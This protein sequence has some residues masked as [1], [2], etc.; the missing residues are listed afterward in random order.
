MASIGE[1][2][3]STRE[4]KGK[5]LEDVSRAT[6]IKIEVLQK[7]EADDYRGIGAPTYVKGFIKLY[8]DYLGLDGKSLGEAYLESQGG[9]RRQGLRLETQ[10][11]LMAER[12]KELQ[13]PLGAVVALVGGL[14]LLLL[15]WWGVR[16]WELHR[17]S[18]PKPRRL[19]HVNVEPFYQPK[20][21]IVAETLEPTGP[22]R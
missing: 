18:P 22:G 17:V 8:G 4:S 12:Q 6:K 15:I 14:T 13:L 5:T 21:R 19:P 9:L 1:I 11:T 7:L 3:R 2:L 10:A 16:T 20:T